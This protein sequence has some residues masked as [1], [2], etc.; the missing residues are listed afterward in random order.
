MPPE[1]VKLVITDVDGVLT[2]G[3]IGLDARGAEVKFFSI[4]DGLGIRLLQLGGIEVAFL[5]SRPSD[6]VRARAEELGVKARFSDIRAKRSAL[7]SLLDEVRAASPDEPLE[8]DDVCYIGDDIVD[9]PCLRRVGFPVAVAN[10]RPEVQEAAEYVTRAEGGRGA[11]R[12][13]ADLVLRA[14]G[15]WDSV[16]EA[17]R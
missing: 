10:A 13:V 9:I 14:R 16:L 15:R 11:F 12:E 7:E 2:D 17:F 3:T 6:V 8:A 4:Q 5:S 1:R